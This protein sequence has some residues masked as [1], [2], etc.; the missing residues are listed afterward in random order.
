MHTALNKIPALFSLLFVLALSAC[1][2]AESKITEISVTEISQQFLDEHLI[3][4]V[5]EPNEFATGYIEN[6]VLMPM[7]SL[8]AQLPAYL[9]KHL[10]NQS[11]DQLSATP[12]L[13][14]CRSGNRSGVAADFLQKMGYTNVVSLKGGMRDWKAHKKAIKLK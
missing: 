3:I 2:Q 10:A 4:D 6:A 12:I 11:T 13:L 7:G 14:Y 5:R 8:Q 9:Q 1:T